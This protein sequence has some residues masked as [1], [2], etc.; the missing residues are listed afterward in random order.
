MRILLC[1]QKPTQ[2]RSLLLNIVQHVLSPD[3]N[4]T[5]TLVTLPGHTE[6]GTVI[7]LDDLEEVLAATSPDVLLVLA[8]AI[9]LE[10]ARNIAKAHGSMEVIAITRTGYMMIDLDPRK[11]AAVLRALVEGRKSAAAKPRVVAGGAGLLRVEP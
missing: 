9:G 1:D 10:R 3:V 8:D 7:A 5:F 11:L 6:Q 4:T 2:E